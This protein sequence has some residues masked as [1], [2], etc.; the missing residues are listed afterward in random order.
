MGIAIV[1]LR[2]GNQLECAREGLSNSGVAE[3]ILAEVRDKQGKE[4]TAGWVS[5][6]GSGSFDANEAVAVVP[7]VAGMSRRAYRRCC[8]GE[9]KGDGGGGVT[10]DDMIPPPGF[11]DLLQEIWDNNTKGDSPE[12]VAGKWNCF[13]DCLAERNPVIR[14][15]IQRCAAMCSN[16]LLSPVCFGCVLGLG[17]VSWSVILSCAWRCARA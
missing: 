12:E 14:E 9:G 5:C 1:T 11:A 7:A 2:N 17:A 4:G 8:C 3:V 13:V 10:P 6:G 15:G 16:G